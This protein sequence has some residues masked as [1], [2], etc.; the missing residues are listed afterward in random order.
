MQKRIAPKFLLIALAIILI[1]SVVQADDALD[2]YM[3]GENAAR[4]GNYIDAITY[5]NSAIAIDQKYASALSGKAYALIR[6]GNYTEALSAAEQALAI[7]QDTRALNAKADALFKLQRY[8]EAVTAY[9][10]FFAV[11]SNL[12]E[13]FCNQG[14]AYEQLNKSENAI[15]AFETCARLDPSNLFPWYRKG[16]ALLT[17]GKPQDALNAFNH[18]TQITISDAEVWNY[19]GVAFLQL[20]KYQDALDCFKTALSIDLTYA[21]AKKNKELAMGRAQVYNNTGTPLPTTKPVA[22][23][24]SESIPIVTETTIRATATVVIEARIETPTL[25]QTE[26][27]IPV[28]T[29][30]SPLPAW[31]P[32][33]GIVGAGVVLLGIRKR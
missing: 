19:K 18:C 1:V 14:V 8:D 2:W 7:K 11:Q 17:L 29:T 6:I 12:P 31:A 25:K 10:K 20:G 13:S 9:D 23:T 28:K 21:E 30:Y 27:A 33:A 26:T 5:Y 3:R 32:I 4:V 16:R 24:T 22:T 15:A